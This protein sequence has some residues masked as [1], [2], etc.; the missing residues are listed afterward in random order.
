MDKGGWAAIVGAALGGASVKVVDYYLKKPDKNYRTAERLRE[1]LRSELNV[2]RV[3][4]RALADELDEWKSKYYTLL[5][6]HVGCKQAC[7]ALELQIKELNSR[8]SLHLQTIPK[9]QP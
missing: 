9:P 8:L 5:E 6:E 7:L 3:E 4:I 1:E 2:M